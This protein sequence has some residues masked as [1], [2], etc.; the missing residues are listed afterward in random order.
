MLYSLFSCHPPPQVTAMPIYEYQC[1]SCETISEEWCR[2]FEDTQNI[3]CPVCG[4]DAHRLI[5]RT[6][7]ALKG[8]GWY[9]T[10]YGTM[11]DAAKK[12]SPAEAPAAS[13]AEAP[14]ASPVAPSSGTNAPAGS[15][16]SPAAAPA[17]ASSA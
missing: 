11:K 12:D 9:A 15:A 13:P 17:P 4:K 6:S 1:D 10:E 8:S 3:H 14:S 16:T 7:F 5:S 2:H